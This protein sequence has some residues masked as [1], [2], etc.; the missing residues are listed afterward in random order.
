VNEQ[1]QV[2]AAKVLSGFYCS[3]IHLS[4]CNALQVIFLLIAFVSRL[5]ASIRIS[6]FDSCVFIYDLLVCNVL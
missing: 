2:L 4:F 3:I 6:H 5:K 1:E